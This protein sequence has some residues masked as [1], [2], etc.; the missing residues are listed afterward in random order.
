MPISRRLAIS[1]LCAVNIAIGSAHASDA[2]DT[3]S[4]IAAV[5]QGLRPAAI[6]DGQPVPT[7]LLANEMAALHVPGVSIA[8][9]HEGRIAW[10]KGYGVAEQGGAKI[11][12]ETMFQA[13]SISKSVTTVAALQLVEARRLTLDGDVNDALKAWHVPANA[14][15]ALHPVTLRGLLSHTAGVNVHGFEGYAAGTP[16]PS[17]LQ[18]LDGLN[19]ANSPAIRVVAEPGKAWSYSGGGYTIAQQLIVDT[20]QTPFPK[21]MQ[22]H[23][24]SPAGMQRSTFEQPLPAPW[25]DKAAMPHLESG[26]AV[27]GG[28]HLYPEMAAAGLWTTPS[29]LA[30]L[31]IQ[32]QQALSGKRGK[33]LLPATAKAMLDPVKPGHSMGFDVGGSGRDGYFAKGGDTTGFAGR[34]VAY[35]NRGDGVVILT[36]GANGS[37]LAEDLIRSVAAAYDWPDFLS[38]VR[39]AMDVDKAMLPRLAGTYAYGNAR[40][41]SIRVEDDHLEIAFSPT[42][43][44]RLYAQS[45][46]QWFT[47][48]DDATF[49]FEDAVGSTVAAGQIN[50]GSDSLPFHRV[51]AKP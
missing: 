27:K 18:V 43:S 41:F 11:T 5:E 34:V 35:A 3:A 6:L 14:W 4:R 29:D 1:V 47:L 32:V 28:P 9:I 36:N 19:P 45:A 51:G 12:P 48:S 20:T 31:L 46:S 26:E 8:V 49:V 50:V 33:L 40:T 17:T 22:Q 21:W 23:V 16:V 10:A 2:K 39:K 15:A 30:R 37:V 44:E 38:H 42:S 7:R 13:G 24:L 25:R